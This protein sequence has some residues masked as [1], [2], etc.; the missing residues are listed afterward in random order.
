MV[1]ATSA[2]CKIFVEQ[3]VSVALFFLNYVAGSCT[4]QDF[5][6]GFLGKKKMKKCT[7]K[8]YIVSLIYQ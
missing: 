7:A 6:N 1:L 4:L 8:I 2:V 3:F 5:L